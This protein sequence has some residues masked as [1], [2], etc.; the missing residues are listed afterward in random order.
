MKIAGGV[1]L[2]ILWHAAALAANDPFL[3]LSPP[4]VTNNHVQFTLT[5][6]SPV[7]YVI[8]SSTDLQ[9]WIPV[10]TNA[11]AGTVRQIELEMTDGPA[12]YRAWRTNLPI[13]SAALVAR[14]NINFLGNTIRVDSYDSSDTN[15]STAGL[16]DP[17]KPKAGGDVASIA[18]FIS[19]GNTD[20]KGKLF[21][22]PIGQFSL[23]P[24]GSVGDLNWAGPGIQPGWFNT[25]FQFALPNVSAPYAL[26]VPPVPKGTN[27]WLLG[28]AQ[29]IHSG[30]L[31]V[32]RTNTISVFGNATVYVTGDANIAGTINILPGASLKLYVGG[33]TATLGRINSDGSVASFQYF[34]LPSNKSLSW[35]GNDVFV[36]TI[37]APQASVTLGGGG[38][39]PFDFSGSCVA[40]SITISGH[41]SF[42]YDEVL[43]R[44]GPQR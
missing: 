15:Y 30:N 6:E 18:G 38:S 35:S 24:S 43:K 25:N 28:S 33:N 13:F 39:D 37:Y 5:G 1:G 21:T 32:N 26:G 41:F 16:Y 2:L 17:T 34:G 4:V 10:A 42:H 29:Y 27:F 22:G 7:T 19:V 44:K 3:Q 8:E 12:F 11:A 20:I 23:G 9:S 40:E 31:S 14:S 36:G